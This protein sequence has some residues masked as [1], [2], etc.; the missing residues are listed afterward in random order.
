MDKKVRQVIMLY[1]ATFF[2]AVLNFIASK[3]NTDYLQPTEYGDVRYVLNFIQL[4]SW[5]V[6]FG[7]YM[8]GSRLLALSDDKRYSARIRGTLVVCLLVSA[9]MLMLSTLVVGFVHTDNTGLRHLFFFA[10]PVAVYPLLTNYMNT[11]AQGDN[12]I[13]RLALARVLPVLCYIPIALLLYRL[14]GADSRKVILLHWGVCSIVMVLIIVSTGPSFKELKPVFGALRDENKSYGIKL[15]WGS[16]TM[17]ATNYL[18]GVTLGWFNDDNSNVGFYTLALSLAQPLSYLPGI[19]GTTYFRHFTRES[20]IPGK[21][22]IITLVITLV[23]C[24]GFI[25]LIKPIVS[26]YDESYSIVAQYAALLA[27]GFSVHGIGDMIN[28]YLGSHG[29]GNTIR[30]CSFACGA[31]K[32]AGSLLLVWLWNVN[33]AV[34]TLIL[35]STVYTLSLY[36]GYRSFI[37]GK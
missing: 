23:S 12:H 22:F 24:L 9:F 10:I 36:I 33:G 6:L 13:G 21:V 18:A 8:S 16:L 1:S 20:R 15:Y 27:I 28:R 29:Q 11:T 34:I 19:V 17:V 32:I 5:V 4:V 30:N 14:Y 25:L 31:V 7:W 37:R 35:S 2:G 3:V 26:L